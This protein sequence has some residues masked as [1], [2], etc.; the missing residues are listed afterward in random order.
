MIF[1]DDNFDLLVFKHFIDNI[2][3]REIVDRN[4]LPTDRNRIWSDGLG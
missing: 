4:L 3:K 2:I 1:L